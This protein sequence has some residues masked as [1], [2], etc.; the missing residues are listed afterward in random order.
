LVSSV[1]AR[2]AIGG[3]LGCFGG[4]GCGGGGLFFFHH[5]PDRLDALR[6]AMTAVGSGCATESRAGGAKG[7]GAPA[8]GAKPVTLLGTG[9]TAKASG[10]GARQSSARGSDDGARETET[11]D[12]FKQISLAGR[13][14]DAG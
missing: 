4:F 11:A 13:L 9:G 3:A 12:S 5:L 6:R 1:H 2:R 10:D 14:L 8:R 7:Q